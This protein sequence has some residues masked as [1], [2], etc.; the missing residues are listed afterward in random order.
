MTCASSTSKPNQIEGKANA[1]PRAPSA[2]RIYR[3]RPVV[4]GDRA[5]HPKWSTFLTMVGESYHVYAQGSLVSR[6]RC[7]I[8]ELDQHALDGRP[9]GGNARRPA[10]ALMSPHGAVVR[11]QGHR[12]SIRTGGLLWKRTLTGST[13][14][15]RSAN[16]MRSCGRDALCREKL[17]NAGLFK[18]APGTCRE[19][20]DRVNRPERVK[21]ETENLR[22]QDCDT[23]KKAFTWLDS[24]NIEYDFHDYKK[25]GVPRGNSSNGRRAR[26]GKS[27]PI[28]ADR[29]GAKFPEAQRQ[30]LTGPRA[31]ALLEQNSSA[32]KRPV[33]EIGSA[34]L[35]GFDPVEFEAALQK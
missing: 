21:S 24:R 27:S 1:P 32:I 23:M 20:P 31:L 33:V 2:L 12:R 9:A 35:I 15:C 8:A 3:V 13:W 25:D 10:G 18:P 30:N 22:H 7:S 19:K 6:C 4:E 14:R 29:P 11:S 17:W 28:R 16:R 5:A 26:A 34:L